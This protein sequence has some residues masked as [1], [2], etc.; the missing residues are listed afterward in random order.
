M[1]VKLV[2]KLRDFTLDVEITGHKGE[3]IALIGEN[4]SGKSTILNLI[5]G[6]IDPD[7]G[8]IS[9]D[10]TILLDTEQDIIIAPEMRHIGYVFQNYALF[11]HLNVYENI[12]F[13]LKRQGTI[14]DSYLQE[15]NRWLE[16]LKLNNIRNENVTRLSGGQQQRV[17][18]AR[19]IVTRPNL[20]LLDEPLSALDIDSRIQIREELHT[21]L[22]DSGT[23]SIIVT[24][25]RDDAM[26]LADRICL[27]ERGKILYEGPAEMLYIQD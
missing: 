4:G 8:V 20:L 21:F 19:A 18:L 3:I 2:K 16:Y 22:R 1:R 5:S 15:V 14:S 24:H 11:P 26:E 25:N 27:L 6:L 17:A 7:E 23:T 9:L 13:G 10:G 12:I